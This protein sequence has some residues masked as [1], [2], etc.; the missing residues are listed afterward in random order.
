MQRISYADLPQGMFEKLMEIETY[1]DKSSLEIGLLELIRLYVAYLNGCA[2]CVDMHYKELQQTGESE[3]RMI[4]LPVWEETPYYSEK[5]R[6]VLQFTASLTRLNGS[7]ISNEVFNPLL[8]FFS[9]EEISFLILA[10]AQI[11]TWTRLMK[12][13]QFTPGQYKVRKKEKAA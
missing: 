6:L 11:N 13:F 10:I 4:S 7:P 9:K 8:D 12:A 5:E 1:I 2:Y 3:L